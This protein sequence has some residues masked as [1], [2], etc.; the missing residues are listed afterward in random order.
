MVLL[1]PPWDAHSRR[2]T[3]LEAIAAVAA[4]AKAG[5]VETE[6]V[7][8]KEEAGTVNAGGRR[9][10]D[11]RHEPAAQALAGEVACMA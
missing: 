1:C 4:G 2:Q 11:S 9:P 8:F 10:I 5:F 7:D 3:A 6:I